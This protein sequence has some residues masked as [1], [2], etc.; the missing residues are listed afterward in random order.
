M[1]EDHETARA[2]VRAIVE[3]VDR[4][5][6]AGV[7]EHL[8]AYHELLTEHIKKEDEI[9][10]PWLDRQL[11][12]TQVGRLFAAFN[13]RDGQFAGTFRKYEDFVC[14]ME[15]RFGHVAAAPARKLA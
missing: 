7:V 12:D 11:S 1:R 10:Y 6:T 3:A 4:R 14:I 2:H 15:Q 8:Q 13:E 9:L 5:R